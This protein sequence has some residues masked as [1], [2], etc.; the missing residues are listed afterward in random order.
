M[1]NVILYILLIYWPT[2]P[3]IWST[4]YVVCVCGLCC[5]FE[6]PFQYF[7]EDVTYIQQNPS[8]FNVR[9]YEFLTNAVVQW[10]L[11]SRYRT[12]LLPH[13]VPPPPFCGCGSQTSRWFPVSD[14]SSSGLW[15]DNAVE[16]NFWEQERSEHLLNVGEI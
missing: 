5:I 11:Q 4:F 1:P 10:L 13:G 2:L 9:F 3:F 8:S 16:W 14:N 12:I 6:F 7:Y 15:T